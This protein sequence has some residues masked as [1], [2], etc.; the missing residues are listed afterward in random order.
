MTATTLAPCGEIYRSRAGRP[1][2]CGR[3]AGTHGDQHQGKPIGKL[4]PRSPLAFGM[5][6]WGPLPGTTGRLFWDGPGRGLDLVVNDHHK[7]IEHEFGR[8]PY[9][10]VKEAD[11]DAQAFVAV[12]LHEE[13]KDNA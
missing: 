13:E 4:V 11:A 10:T 9:A 1:L 6:E 12:Y 2:R 3:P 7:P 5:W 8:G